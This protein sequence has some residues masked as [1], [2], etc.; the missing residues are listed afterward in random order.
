MIFECVGINTTMNQAIE[1]ARKGSH[2]VVVGVFGDLANMNAALIQDHEL[3]L[4]GSAMY[5]IEDYKTAIELIA[6]GRID[7]DSL[8]THHV[9]FR[10]YKRAYQIIDEQKDKAMKVIV[11]MDE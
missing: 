9:T 3:T 4:V 1:Y 6:A 11:V 5:R 7:F 8:I 2:I 10:E